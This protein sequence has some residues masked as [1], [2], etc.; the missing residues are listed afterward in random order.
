MM[1][2]GLVDAGRIITGHYSLDQINDAL[3]A[4]G[5]HRDL[6]GVIVFGQS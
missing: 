2:S 1:E 4:S 3:H 5:T 6:S